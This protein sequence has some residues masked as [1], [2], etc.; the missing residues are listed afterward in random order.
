MQI[1]INLNMY[2]CKI[3]GWYCVKFGMSK[4]WTNSDIKKDVLLLF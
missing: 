3:I 2:A 4:Q 1:C